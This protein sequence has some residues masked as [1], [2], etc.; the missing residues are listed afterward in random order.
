MS[1]EEK[2]LAYTILK[3]IEQTPES[4]LL[5]DDEISLV[6]AVVAP[7]VSPLV[8]GRLFDFFRETSEQVADDSEG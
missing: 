2:Y 4:V 6:K 5:S 3:K 7:F 1:S 8:Y